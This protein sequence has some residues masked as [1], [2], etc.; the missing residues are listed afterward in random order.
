MTDAGMRTVHCI[1]LAD[2]GALGI[3]G[4]MGT[5]SSPVATTVTRVRTMDASRDHTC[6]SDDGN[7]IYCWG[8][9]ASGQCGV[10]PPSPIVATPTAIIGTSG[11]DV[12]VGR[13]HSCALLAGEVSCWGA[14]DRGQLGRGSIGSADPVPGA[15]TGIS[16]AMEIEAGGDHTCARLLDGGVVRC[17]G[18]NHASQLGD[19]TS[20]DQA[21]PVEVM[22][23]ALVI[24][25]GEQHTC[26]STD[27]ETFCWGMRTGGRLGDGIPTADH[28]PALVG[29]ASD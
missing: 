14:N 20:G 22:R 27:A 8:A 17:W 1:G 29:E 15:V 11:I 10:S 3:A 26:A 25:A 13:A 21:T 24:A 5:R 28:L 7:R 9:N 4:E 18:A 2:T 16:G 19:G 23:G 12:A 6:A